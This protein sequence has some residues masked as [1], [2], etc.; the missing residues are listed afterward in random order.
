MTVEQVLERFPEEVSLR[1]GSKV[2]VRP[3]LKDDVQRLLR[4]FREEVL[5]EDIA[6]LKDDVKSEEVIG[7]WCS[8]LDYGRV[9]PLVAIKEDRIVAN[10]SLHMRGFG[11]A[12]YVG[13]VRITTSFRHRRKGLGS[14]M[15]KI[16]EEI[17][18]ELMLE[19]LWAEMIVGAQDAAIK[20]FE[21]A[22][23]SCEGVLKRIATD[24]SGNRY[25][26]AIYIKRL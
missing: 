9:L 10:A 15:L 20:L 14:Q 5:E 24:P 12:K 26:L 4:F 22:G 17:A 18:R 13:K 1:D 6:F 3:L 25:D 11:W 19:R 21:K 16:I 7:R 8:H 23:Y 2:V